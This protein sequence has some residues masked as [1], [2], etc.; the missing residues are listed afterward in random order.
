M[1]T[2]GLA[3][4]GEA[5]TKMKCR[6]ATWNVNSIRS[7]L[8]HT[9]EWLSRDPVDIVLLQELKTVVDQLPLIEIEELGYNVRA[10]GEKSYNGVAILSRFPLEVT[11]ESLPGNGNDLQARYIE[12]EVSLPGQA[13]RVASVYVPNGQEV[14]SEKFS[15]KLAFLDRLRMHLSALCAH[16]E[17]CI[18]GGDYNIAPE[19]LDVYAPQ[20]L[21]GS[22]CF[23]PEERARFR[24]LEYL[25]YYD[26]FRLVHPQQ[27]A[28]SWW[29]YR[30][31]S[32]QSGKGMRIDHLLLS[33]QAADRAEDCIILSDMRGAEKASDHA[34][35]VVTLNL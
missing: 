25:G 30:G 16:D 4:T 13:L 6:I 33:P 31:G 12:A 11:Q 10:V 8:Q 22:V 1:D 14:G 34:P 35:V 21:D 2:P 28:F 23:H 24:A 20:T 29:D 26:A 19:P 32:W 7:R 5:Q 17:L 18:I 15:Y 3:T 9:L 27:Q